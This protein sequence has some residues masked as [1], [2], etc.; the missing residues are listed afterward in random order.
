MMEPF[1]FRL[2]YQALDC[3]ES[4]MSRCTEAEIEALGTWYDVDQVAAD[5]DSTCENY[6]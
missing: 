4:I 2:A 5:I 3:L 1:I 6:N